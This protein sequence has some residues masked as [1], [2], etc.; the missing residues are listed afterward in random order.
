[1]GRMW[2]AEEAVKMSHHSHPSPISTSTEKAWRRIPFRSLRS[3]GIMITFIGGIA[4]LSLSIFEVGRRAGMGLSQW[5]PVILG[6]D[7]NQIK[8]ARYSNTTFGSLRIFRNNDA[9][10]YDAATIQGEQ[11]SESTYERLWPGYYLPDWAHKVRR[12][13]DFQ[14][15]MG[16][17]ICYVHVG[18]TAGSSIGCALGFCL[19]CQDDRQF[20]PGRLPKSAT[21]VFH[22]SV[23]DCPSTADFYLIVVRD[24]LAR[25]RSAFVYGRPDEY[26]HSA[27]GWRYTEQLYS[28]CPFS[29]ANELASMGLTDNGEAS[30]E[31]KQRAKDMLR[32]VARYE[33]HMFY[34]YQ[35]YLESIPHKS[36][37]L[38]IRTEHM[39][40]DW[41]KI[42]LRLGGTPRTNL[43]FPHDNSKPKEARDSVLGNDE[44]M[45]LCHEL[46]IEIQM[47]KLMLQNTL[48]IDQP[49][50]N[51]SMEEL[52]A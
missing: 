2:A 30:D 50:Y 21:H 1:M 47:Y 22:K 44:R 13:R 19:R 32:G 48:N 3:L 16:N 24:P 7:N 12:F 11:H 5:I 27:E 29:T 14:P 39:E 34:N 31:C 17:S 40:E 4:L 15:P 25:S 49:Q 26:G 18:K 20:L 51:I 23:Y 46:C 9:K 35:Y 6:D 8:V 10:G 28:D 33:D 45:L 38:V 41:N 36:N 52:Q 43:T 37:I 42:E